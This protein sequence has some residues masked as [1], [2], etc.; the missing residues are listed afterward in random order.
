LTKE[1]M[2]TTFK[3]TIFFLIR[4]CGASMKLRSKKTIVKIVTKTKR[5]VTLLI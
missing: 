1:T 5:K 4:V 2:K 3:N